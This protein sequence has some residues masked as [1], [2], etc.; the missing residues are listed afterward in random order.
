[1]QTCRGKPASLLLATRAHLSPYVSESPERS[2]LDKTAFDLQAAMD[3]SKDLSAELW[4]L[5]DAE[6]A[7]IRERL[8][9]VEGVI[10]QLH[11]QGIQHPAFANASDDSILI[12]SGSRGPGDSSEGSVPYSEREAW[13][14][15][16]SN[17]H[18]PPPRS[19]LSSPRSS[20]WYDN[21]WSSEG[22]GVCVY[23]PRRHKRHG[24]ESRESPRRHWLSPFYRGDPE[25]S[26]GNIGISVLE[27]PAHGARRG[28]GMQLKE[29]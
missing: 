29:T 15:G 28:V 19:T 4:P 13:W 7:A 22:S 20:V 1:M 11:K 8:S 26:P 27:T 14:H 25:V 16:E 3:L 12:G 24:S 18:P 23:D 17:S 5:V 2:S 21:S 6:T 10:K 9:N